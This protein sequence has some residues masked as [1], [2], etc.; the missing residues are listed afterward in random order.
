MTEERHDRQIRVP[1]VGL[2]GQRRL[3]AAR[4]LV[5]GVGG[6]GSA[7]AMALA[8]AGIG[9]YGLLGRSSGLVTDYS[10][11]WVDYL[12]LDRPLAFLVPDLVTYTRALV[13]ADVLEWLPGELVG[14]DEPFGEFVADLDAA[15]ALGSV[16]RKEVAERIGLH[17]SRT[18]AQ[19]LV[20]ALAERGALR[21]RS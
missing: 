9:L 4:V 6:V 1:G 5:V 20:A 17:R 8:R 12:L 7:A 14:D 16:L 10:S 15:G 19:D 18:S 3:A 2:A 11:V 21:T 13:P